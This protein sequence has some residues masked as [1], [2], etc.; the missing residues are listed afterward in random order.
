MNFKGRTGKS[1]RLSSLFC[2]EFF[3]IL[4]LTI[5]ATGSLG[6]TI[7]DDDYDGLISLER[8]SSVVTHHEEFP[9][10]WILV[11]GVIA[12]L[13]TISC[14]SAFFFIMAILSSKKTRSMDS[15]N[16]YM[17]FLVIPDALYNGVAVFES[18]YMM[19]DGWIHPMV[20]QINWIVG[21]FYFYCN[22]WLNAVIA[23]EIFVVVLGSK[24]RVKP[25]PPSVRKAC[26]QSV[27]VYALCTALSIWMVNDNPWSIGRLN[28]EDGMCL[29]RPG[30]PSRDDG[31]PGWF[32]EEF[33]R[34]L[35][36]IMYMP[37]IYVLYIYCRIFWGKLLPSSGRTRVL[38]GYFMRILIIYFGCVLP[39]F[40]MRIVRY[41]NA[42]DSNS[43]STIAFWSNVVSEFFLPV[44][45]MVT[46]CL[47]STKDDIR[48]A[49]TRF[50]PRFLSREKIERQKSC[51]CTRGSSHGCVDADSIVAH[52]NSCHDGSNLEIQISEWNQDDLYSD[53]DNNDNNC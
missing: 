49:V 20:C 42:K 30:S 23:H 16:I 47:A 9:V 44:Q 26:F 31:T 7:V 11:Q 41:N 10:V 3:P 36:Y 40:A 17:V 2:C 37:W 45:T 5:R 48:D 33:G 8:N 38:S 22:F 28:T 46:L 6:E 25:Q 34:K 18:A 32:S 1:R 12:V 43:S 13:M 39:S 4:S 24:K 51:V 50:F 29:Y 21:L 14:F 52:S 35:M 53:D 19:N 15:Y 27:F